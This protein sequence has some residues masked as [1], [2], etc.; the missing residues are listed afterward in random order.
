MVLL[1]LDLGTTAVKA[2]ILDPQRGLIAARSLPNAP[3]S[4]HPGWSEQ[5]AGAWLENA[6]ELIPLT[7]S[8]AGIEASAIGAVGV[9]GCVP[10]TLLLDAD[11]RALRPALLY[12]DARAH[13]EIDELTAELHDSRVLERT[14]AGI[15]QQ[16]VGPKLRWLRRHEPELWARTRRVAGSYDWLAGQLAGARYSERNWALESGLYDLA[17][18]TYA[19]DLCAAA[20]VEPALL[21]PI[22]DPADVVGGISAETAAR[23]GLRAGIPVVAGLADHVSSAFGAGLAQDGDLLVKLGGSVDVLACSDHPLLDER[24]YLDAHPSAG[25]WL[26]NGCMASGGSAVRWFQRELAAGEALGE[27]DDEAAA[28]PPGAGGVVLLPYLLGEKTPI[29]DPLARGAFVGLSIGHGRGHLFRALLESFAFGVRHHLEVLAEHGVHPARARV[30]NGGASSRLWKQIVAD[31]TGLVLEPVVD[32]P[33]SALGAA[34]AA[35]MGNGAFAAWSEID[36]FVT[37]GDPVLPRPETAAVYDQR[38]ATYRALY[39]ALR[40]SH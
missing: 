29:N 34:Y 33:G 25:L 28:T 10:C 7:C 18:G 11:D 22:R 3:A 32:H 37:L 36:R 13:A 23:S 9:A 2:V 31:V 5:D 17:R 21:G 16:S 6:F 20:G 35:G 39:D 1:G 15:T 26:P 40:R 12:N 38:Y 14:G 4:P 24:L 30:T 27:L 8:E 19:P